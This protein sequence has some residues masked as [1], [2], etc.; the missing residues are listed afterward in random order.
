MKYHIMIVYLLI[1]NFFS[2]IFNASFIYQTIM[3]I[4]FITIFTLPIKLFAQGDNQVKNSF[5]DRLFYGGNFGLMFGTITYVELSP[6]I[7]YKITERLSFGPGVSY[8][9]MKDNRYDLSTSIY[10]GRL[11]AR[12]NITDYLFGH[13]EYE[14]LNLE[15]PYSLKGRT[16]LTSIFIG[17]GYRQSLGD[18]SFLTIMGLWNINDSAYSIYRNPIIRVG[19]STGF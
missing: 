4:F 15:T 3:R 6:L 13:G 12:Y 7:G 16:N 11:F 17:G 8:I 19:I 10:G 1:L 9:Y 5:T 14:V 2:M 18:R